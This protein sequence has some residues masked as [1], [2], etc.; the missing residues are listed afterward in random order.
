MASSHMLPGGVEMLCRSARDRSV[1]KGAPAQ[2]GR[3]RG[4]RGVR[5]WAVERAER[6]PVRKNNL[7]DAGRDPGS[8]GVCATRPQVRFRWGLLRGSGGRRQK[9][10]QCWLAWQRTERQQRRRRGESGRCRSPR[11]A[12]GDEAVSG[13][14][15][16]PTQLCGG[17]V[18][19]EREGRCVEG[20]LRVVRG[21]GWRLLPVRYGRGAGGVAAGSGSGSPI[22]PAR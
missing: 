18:G 8:G 22:C 13:W 11:C 21:E 10:V 15:W 1:G 20:L 16:G 4:G 12:A 7:R 9:R 17:Q 5:V 6:L 2:R 3:F 14:R 19:R